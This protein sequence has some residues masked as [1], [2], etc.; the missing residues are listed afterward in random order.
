MCIRGATDPIVESDIVNGKETTSTVISPDSLDYN[1]QK[2]QKHELQPHTK[3]DHLEAGLS[4][5]L[6]LSI[7]PAWSS[8]IVK[9]PHRGH[10]LWRFDLVQEEDFFWSHYQL[11]LTIDG[12]RP[13]GKFSQIGSC[14]GW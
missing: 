4:G 10:H 7:L 9:P 8:A 13:H 3:E 14:T 5:D 11:I 12:S 1:L 6:S 2:W